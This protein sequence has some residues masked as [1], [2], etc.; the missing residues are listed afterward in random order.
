MRTATADA[1]KEKNALVIMNM[2]VLA[3]VDAM[4][5]ATADARMVKNA[6]VMIKN[7]KRDYYEK[8]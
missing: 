7:R 6:L 1:G 2:D 8:I 4:I 3:D 5:L